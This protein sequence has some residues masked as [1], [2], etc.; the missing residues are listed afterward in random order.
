[1]QIL[2]YL[3]T[4]F[5]LALGIS[6]YAVPI[7]IRVAH[8]LKLLDNPNERSAAEHP[9][10]T[11]GGIAIFLSFIFASTIGLSGNEMPELIYIVI[12]VILMF[13]V[14]LKDDILTLSPWKKL[15]AQLITASIIIFLAKIR[16]TNLHGFLGIE[17][18]GIIPST[19]LT[20]FAII[21]IINAFNL[22]DGIDGLAGGLS[23]LAAT[24]FGIWF[25][26]SGHYD[27]AVLSVSLIGAI[28]GFFYFNVYGKTFKIFM[29]DTGSLVL[30]TIMS[31][32][33]IR[34]NE[35]NIDQTQPFAMASAPAISFGILIYPLAD[36]L[37][38]FIIRALQFKS[39]FVADKNHLHHR[40]LTLGFSHK[41]ATYTIILINSLFIFCIVCLKHLGIVKVMGFILVI[42]SFL[43][44]IPA[45]FIHKRNLINKNDPHQQLL[46]PGSS[47]KLLRYNR[48]AI[49]VAQ[50]NTPIR[51]VKL[52][53]F[54]QKLNLW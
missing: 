53:T 13:F 51:G 3:I 2:P 41:K 18:I 31:I 19:F 21:V 50:R 9:I 52:Q 20:F 15:T 5:I 33:V 8:S 45:Y 7:V 40:L 28:A 38:V 24:V 42:S 26:I 16:F 1:M 44:L 39:P 27:Y 37:R 12:A 30:G 4:S 43:F 48:Y 46:I 14:G 6:L 32:I 54:L 17:Q 25:F 49:K 11:L 35:F 10:P 29:G 22:M 34:F 36:T 23:M 47:Y